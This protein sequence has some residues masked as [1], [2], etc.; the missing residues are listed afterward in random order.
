MRTNTFQFQHVAAQFAALG[1]LALAAVTACSSSDGGPAAS[2][3][4]TPAAEPTASVPAAHQGDDLAAAVA[5]YTAAYFAA[6]TDTAYGMMSKRCA[7]QIDR[8]SYRAVLEQ[9][10]ADYGPD[11]PA[12]DVKAEVSGTLG[13]ATYK[14]KG[15]PKLDQQAQPWTL[16]SKAW[17]YDAC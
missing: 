13:R 15:L 6:D 11:H 16:E 2:D 17:K 8:D 14:V 12:T 1:A 10:K 9:A 4:G 7:G 3:S 5:V